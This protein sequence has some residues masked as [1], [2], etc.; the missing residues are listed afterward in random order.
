KSNKR[1]VI[2]SY[3]MLAVELESLTGEKLQIAP[4]NTATLMI[5]VPPS[6]ASSAPSTISLWYVNEQT[7]AWQEEG[8]AQKNGNFYVGEVKHFSFWNCD[9]GASGVTLSMTF[10]S[11]TGS[12]LAYTE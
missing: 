9:I 4:G 1:V 11:F 2:T 7:G 3:G 8:T 10:H 6:V 12:P 5:P